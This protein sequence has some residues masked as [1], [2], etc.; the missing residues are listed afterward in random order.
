MN[1]ITWIIYLASVSDVVLFFLAA[2]TVVGAGFLLT[3]GISA[4]QDTDCYENRTSKEKKN[5]THFFSD[6]FNRIRG[7]MILCAITGVLFTLIPGERTIYLMASS[8]M[9]EKM[10]KSK[11]FQQIYG[12]LYQ[13]LNGKLDDMIPKPKEEKKK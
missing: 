6:Y 2:N 1:N 9:A 5:F 3:A 11:D 12:K 13:V 8:E 10:V 7:Y 4:V